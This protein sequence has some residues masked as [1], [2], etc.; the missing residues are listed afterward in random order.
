M[1]AENTVDLPLQTRADV[2][3]Q[4]GTIDAEARTVEVL[5]S[6]G[7]PVPRRDPFTGRRYDEVLSLEP[8]HVDLSRLNAGAPLLNAHGAY[9]L[10]NVLGVVER[11]WIAK[12]G[13]ALEGRAVVRF[14]E[15]E[16]VEPLWQDV[17][18]LDH[19]QR[20]GRL[21]R[22]RLRGAR[23]VPSVSCTRFLWRRH[24]R[25]GNREEQ[26]DGQRI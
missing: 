18:A 5:W 10:L 2:R 4:A 22:P 15:R 20:L 11:A 24:C 9:N 8:R 14:S 1:I 26:K 13:D 16:D 23:A 6:T 21:R 12:A 19:P 25:D 17:R 3:L 7:A